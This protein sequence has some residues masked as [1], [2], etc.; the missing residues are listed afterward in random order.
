MV[1]Y[2]FKQNTKNLKDMTDDELMSGAKSRRTGTKVVRWAPFVGSIVLTLGVFAVLPMPMLVG[3]AASMAIGWGVNKVSAP[4]VN[5]VSS[6]LSTE[7]T[8]MERE[9][10]DRM[11]KREKAEKAAAKQAA[12][13]NNNAPATAA[14]APTPAATEPEAKRAPLV[15]QAAQDFKTAKEAGMPITEDITVR[16]GTLK[17]KKPGDSIKP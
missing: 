8:T 9:M 17:F 16:K 11:D 15:G 2:L 10:L 6:R 5:K 3:F 7:Y 13:A 4:W 12:A 14:P 1:G